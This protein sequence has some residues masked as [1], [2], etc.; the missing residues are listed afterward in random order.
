MQSVLIRKATYDDIPA[1]Y[2]LVQELAAFEKSESS[3]WTTLEDY[4]ECFETA[5]FG[6][7]IAEL[8]SEIIG[9]CL[10]YPTFST[11]KGKMLYLEDFVV[12]SEYRG[13]GVG[14]KLYDAFILEAKNQGCKLVK[15]EVLDWNEG[16]VRFYEKNGA[17]I[18]KNWWD[19]KIFFD[20]ESHNH[21]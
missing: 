9:I 8:N 3:I 21:Q 11:W 2:R 4:Q 7:H 13:K 6:A 17:I 12:S 14:Q 10:Y 18:E 16:A 20:Q 15:W 19:C 1:I 5:L